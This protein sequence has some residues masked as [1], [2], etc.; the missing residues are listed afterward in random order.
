MRISKKLCQEYPGVSFHIEAM[1]QEIS[2]Q[3]QKCY[4]PRDI[5][6]HDPAFSKFSIGVS[7]IAISS[8]STKCRSLSRRIDFN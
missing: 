3:I 2:S 6:C 1:K 7:M 4:I 5:K 8:T